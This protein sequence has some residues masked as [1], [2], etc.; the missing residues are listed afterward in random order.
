M[1]SVCTIQFACTHYMAC[2]YMGKH[3]AG[4][5]VAKVFGGAPACTGSRACRTSSSFLGHTH[6][7]WALAHSLLGA[8]A[9]Q[10]SSSPLCPSQQLLPQEVPYNSWPLEEL[11]PQA[12]QNSCFMPTA[13]L[14]PS[15]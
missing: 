6:Y 11:L 3:R 14:E 9:A 1:A 8:S 5:S 2:A 13:L 12:P 15:A 7:S 10:R 4:K